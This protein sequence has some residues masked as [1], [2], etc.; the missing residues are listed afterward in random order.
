MSSDS[1]PL[2]YTRRRGSDMVQHVDMCVSDEVLKG[3][4]L[5]VVVKNVD[6]RE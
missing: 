4:V 3:N 5:H 6:R 1:F 2:S